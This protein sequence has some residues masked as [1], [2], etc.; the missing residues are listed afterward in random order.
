MATR[1]KATTAGQRASAS[2]EPTWTFLSNHSHVLICLAENPEMT[3]RE[4]SDRVGITERSVQRIVTD[5]EQAGFLTRTRE[6][7]RN[8]YEIDRKLPL[9]HPVEA[10]KNIGDLIRLVLGPRR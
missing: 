10:H 7:V 9:R 6:G 3:L 5:L 8:R 1:K 2:S 4:V